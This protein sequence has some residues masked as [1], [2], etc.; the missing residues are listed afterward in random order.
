M[1]RGW[2]DRAK[3]LRNKRKESGS[4]KEES[5]ECKQSPLSPKRRNERERK[6]DRKGEV[7]YSGHSKGPAQQVE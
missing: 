5:K 7:L 3:N 4:G 1:G 2:A 6:V